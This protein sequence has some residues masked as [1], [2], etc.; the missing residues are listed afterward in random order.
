M[1]RRKDVHD[2]ISQLTHLGVRKNRRVRMTHRMPWRKAKTGRNLRGVPG[3]SCRR[4][5]V[6]LQLH[7]YG[8]Y[9]DLAIHLAFTDSGKLPE[10]G[11]PHE[12][13]SGI[14]E[15]GIPARSGNV[16]APLK[17]L[18]PKVRRLRMLS[19]IHHSW[20]MRSSPNPFLAGHT[21]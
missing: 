20:L 3:K 8:V 12:V 2:S 13:R 5:E 11:S 4:C 10:D 14:P 15:S 7:D 9:Q 19:E 16:R 21:Q 1:S 17:G 6:R 18:S